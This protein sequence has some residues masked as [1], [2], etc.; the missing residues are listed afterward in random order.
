M[1]VVGHQLLLPLLLLLM[2]QLQHASSSVS[3]SSPYSSAYTPYTQRTISLTAGNGFLASAANGNPGLSG[4]ASSV[5]SIVGAS[6]YNPNLTGTQGDL[7]GQQDMI[8]NSHGLLIQG[9]PNHQHQFG[10][11][12]LPILLQQ[13]QQ[14]QQQA[15]LQPGQVGA[16]Q[17]GYSTYP[18]ARPTT[19]YGATE[20]YTS[21]SM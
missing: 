9:Q 10:Q 1:V 21:G 5:G 7:T 15:P 12:Q 4:A 18:H 14:Q 17:Y 19:Q 20:Y 8:P 16:N 11:Q 13:Q 3:V 6:G 2:Q